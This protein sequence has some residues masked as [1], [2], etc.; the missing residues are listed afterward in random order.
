MN[1]ISTG[2]S[3]AAADAITLLTDALRELLSGRPPR[4]R[5][6][7]GEVLKLLD[8]NTPDMAEPSRADLVAA[9]RALAEEDEPILTLG[10]G[11][12]SVMITGNGLRTGGG[13][14]Y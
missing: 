4:E 1:L 13:G 11:K 7:H 10:G 6:S 2:H 5:L 3:A 14:D 12:D 8:A 9:L